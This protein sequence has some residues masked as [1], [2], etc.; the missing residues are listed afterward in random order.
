ML[1]L[2]LIQSDSSRALLQLPLQDVWR[3]SELARSRS[4]TCTTGH[5]VLDAELP[6]GGCG[7]VTVRQ[8]PE[9]AKG[10][11]FV[12]IEDES[13]TVNVI[14]W[15][16]LVEQQRKELMG[17]KLLGVYGVWQCERNV[18]H[19][20]AKRLVDLSHMLGELDT[21]SRNFH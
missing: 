7:I 19:L 20:V 4:T 15:P 8:R 16:N 13:G 6:N 11:I 10:V 12:T 5:A 17:A 1:C 2:P 3:A 18:R 21:R 14:C 9:T